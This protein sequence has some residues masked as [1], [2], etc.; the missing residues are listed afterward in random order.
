MSPHNLAR[1]TR[2]IRIIQFQGLY[3]KEITKSEQ[4]LIKLR[5]KKQYKEYMNQEPVL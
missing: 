1:G 4:K 2:K 3:K 5:L